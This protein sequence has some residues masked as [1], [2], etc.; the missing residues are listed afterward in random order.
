MLQVLLFLLVQVVRIILWF[1]LNLV[2]ELMV[3]VISGLRVFMFL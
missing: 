2:L 1:L 3:S